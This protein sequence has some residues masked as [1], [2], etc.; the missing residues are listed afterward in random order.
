[1]APEPRTITAFF[2]KQLADLRDTLPSARLATIVSE[3]GCLAP[4]AVMQAEAAL[5]ISRLLELTRAAQAMGAELSVG[6]ARCL[7]VD[8]TAGVVIM[9]PIATKKPRVLVVVL[10]DQ[11]DVSRALGG[12]HKLAA[13]IEQRLPA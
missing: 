3:D 12:V 5:H 4:D 9:R 13:E 2:E 8:G 10:G 6:K 7:I 11:H 1:M